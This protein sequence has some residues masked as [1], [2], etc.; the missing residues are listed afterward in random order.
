MFSNAVVLG[1]VVFVGGLFTWM[2]MNMYWQASMPRD[3]YCQ[4][5]SYTVMRIV[6]E[7]A[8][9]FSGDYSFLYFDEKYGCQ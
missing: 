9:L 8:A 7:L 1:F 3:E 5:I 4:T 2:T 6:G